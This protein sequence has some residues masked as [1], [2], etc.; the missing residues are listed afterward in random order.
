MTLSALYESHLA[1]SVLLVLLALAGLA[2]VQWWEKTTRRQGSQR[3]RRRP[4]A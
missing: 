1:W 2:G 4:G 3:D